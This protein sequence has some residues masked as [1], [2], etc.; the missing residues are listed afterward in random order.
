VVLLDL[1]ARYRSIADLG[2]DRELLRLHG[3]EVDAL[4]RV[5]VTELTRR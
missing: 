1:K 2:E 3:P 4:I 5:D